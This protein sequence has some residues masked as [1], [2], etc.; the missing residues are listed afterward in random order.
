L[1]S[2]KKRLIAEKDV[3]M[4]DNA[5]VIKENDKFEVDNEKLNK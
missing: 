2:Q 1:K 3:L 5:Q 4:T